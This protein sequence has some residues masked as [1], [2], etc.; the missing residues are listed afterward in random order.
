MNMCLAERIAMGKGASLQLVSAQGRMT[1]I[2]H[3]ESSEDAHQKLDYSSSVLA[4]SLGRI[5]AGRL[6]RRILGMLFHLHG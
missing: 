5:Q 2:F 4:L 6:I 1:A 3:L